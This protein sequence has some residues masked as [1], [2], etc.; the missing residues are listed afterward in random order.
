M[1]SAECSKMYRTLF[2]MSV[3]G[4]LYLFPPPAVSSFS[5]DW[6][7]FEYGRMAVGF[8]LLLCILFYN[9]NIW[10][11][12]M[13]HQSNIRCMLRV[14]LKLNRAVAGLML[15]FS[16]DSLQSTSCMQNS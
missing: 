16:F 6:E 4:S 8:I 7:I 11:Y 3:C 13:F 14:D 2:M 12:P 1:V 15:C 10:F 5:S 9:S